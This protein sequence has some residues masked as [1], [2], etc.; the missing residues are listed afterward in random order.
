MMI[1]IL[2]FVK[3]GDIYRFFWLICFFCL[4][5]F[6]FDCFIRL[7]ILNNSVLLMSCIVVYGIR[8][9]V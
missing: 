2:N 9:K 6:L 7:V 1:L 3:R 5:F 8:I 4:Y